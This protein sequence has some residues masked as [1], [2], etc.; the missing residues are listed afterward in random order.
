MRPGRG[1]EVK[2]RTRRM[3]LERDERKEAKHVEKEG[4]DVL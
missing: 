4:K 2:E 1:S 3:M